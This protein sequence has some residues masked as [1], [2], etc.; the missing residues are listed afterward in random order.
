MLHCRDA[1]ANPTTTTRSSRYRRRSE[2]LATNIRS[3]AAPRPHK[4]RLWAMLRG[5]A[6][7][8]HPRGQK[9]AAW[10][11]A[12]TAKKRGLYNHPPTRP[13]YSCWRILEHSSSA[14]AIRQRSRRGAPSHARRGNVALTAR[15]IDRALR[16]YVRAFAGSHA[17]PPPPSSSRRLS[18][19]KPS[20]A[21]TRGSHEL[22]RL[23][24][25]QRGHK[26]LPLWNLR[27]QQRRDG[28]RACISAYVALPC[29]QRTKTGRQHCFGTC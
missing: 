12:S 15:V 19:R 3:L 27:T 16:G 10:A 17:L 21:A 28:T 8:R 5:T 14:D 24:A 29:T 9:C 2:H 26:A 6:A 11:S 18:L 20:S 25:Q 7:P 4:Q 23:G 1:S 22:R 13:Y